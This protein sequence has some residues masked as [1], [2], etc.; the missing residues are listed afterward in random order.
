M[1]ERELGNQGSL[2]HVFVD[3]VVVAAVVRLL[4]FGAVLLISS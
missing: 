2:C 4:V 1:V 3:A